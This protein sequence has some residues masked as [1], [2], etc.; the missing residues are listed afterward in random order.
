MAPRP[1]PDPRGGLD[2]GPLFLLPVLLVPI[3][4]MCHQGHKGR[5][6]ARMGSGSPPGLN[7]APP[8]P[9]G[10]GQVEAGE[11]AIQGTVWWSRSW[12]PGAPRPPSLHPPSSA[13][14]TISRMTSPSLS[15]DIS[16]I[17]LL[18][19]L[20]GLIRAGEWL[21][22]APLSV[23]KGVPPKGDSPLP[24][25]RSVSK[26]TALTSGRMKGRLNQEVRLPLAAL[27]PLGHSS[28]VHIN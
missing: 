26:A 20:P 22:S 3:Q 25:S 24:S 17:V 4:E 12:A 23:R 2:K 14:W 27:S 15:L 16:I 21:H 5:P 8:V 11:E 18:S 19:G 10:Q 13:L 6:Q 28:A 9:Q 1:A 7:I